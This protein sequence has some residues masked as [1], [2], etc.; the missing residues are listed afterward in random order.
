MG[1]YFVG[2]LAYADDVTLLAPTLTS[3]KGLLKVVEIFSEK[4]EVIFNATKTKL[5][6]FGNADNL[7]NEF[8]NFH[9]N[10]IRC[11]SCACHFG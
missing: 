4:Y 3:L 2:A 11:D 9:G 1:H 7:S 8:I 5:T 6:K 10:C